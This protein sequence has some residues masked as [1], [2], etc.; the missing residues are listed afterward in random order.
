MEGT[1]HSASLHRNRK[2][3]A[4]THNSQQH[5]QQVS[6]S[7]SRTDTTDQHQARGAGA[8]LPHDC[9][10]S[11]MPTAPPAAA[12]A[13]RPTAAV[14]RRFFFAALGCP[15]IF[16]ALSSSVAGP[17]MPAAAPISANSPSPPKRFLNLSSW[18]ASATRMVFLPCVCVW[19]MEGGGQQKHETGVSASAIRGWCLCPAGDW[20]PRHS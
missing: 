6:N 14:H 3:P 19:W 17:P 1:H 4:P 13:G 10:P 20:R 12:G 9:H 2:L 11:H 16:L 18:P 5:Q 8:A 7:A 15:P